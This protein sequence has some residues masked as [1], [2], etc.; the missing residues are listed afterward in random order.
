M[1]KTIVIAGSLAQRPRQGGHTWV[2]LQYLLGFRRL[3]WPDNGGRCVPMRDVGGRGMSPA[4]AA[5]DP[6]ATLLTLVTIPDAQVP[7]LMTTN[8]WSR[9]SGGSR[10]RKSEHIRL[11]HGC[12][13]NAHLR[14]KITEMRPGRGA[15]GAASQPKPATAEAACPKPS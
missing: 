5:A 1:P 3:G 11:L 8:N 6:L 7:T 10:D 2:F 4:T 9:G 14:G 15:F 12:A 13:G